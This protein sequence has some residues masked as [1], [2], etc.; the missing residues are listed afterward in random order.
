MTFRAT[1][2]PGVILIEPKVHGDERGF[3]VET[4]HEQRYAENGIPLRFVQ[5]NHSRSVGPILRGLHAQRTRA[6]G[7]LV[8]C[9]E[10]RIFD[11]AV[12]IRRGSP[13]FAQWVGF[14]LSAANFHQLW[15]PPDFAHGFCVLDGG[16]VQVEYKCTD[17]YDPSD[18]LGVAWDDPDL[19]VEWPIEKPLLSPKDRALGRLADLM[20]R[21]PIFRG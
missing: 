9:V 4:Y 1:K 2:L 21:L 7:K 10:G 13:T 16:P 19:G 6:Q 14:E 20:D 5:D 18:E 11:V 8:R 3:F 17:L 12:D 15:I